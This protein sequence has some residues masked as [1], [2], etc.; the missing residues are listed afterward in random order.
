MCLYTITQTLNPPDHKVRKAWKIVTGR[1]SSPFYHI[2]LTSKWST[3]N[4]LEINSGKCE[5]KYITG[6][7]SYFSK[8]D[9][10]AMVQAIHVDG[11][12]SVVPVEIKDITYIGTDGTMWYTTPETRSIRNYVSNKIRLLPIKKKKNKK[13][14]K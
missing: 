6:F 12:Y 7:H 3:A 8:K 1:N 2:I 14:G 11:Q 4:N 10:D 9:A 5:D 13:K